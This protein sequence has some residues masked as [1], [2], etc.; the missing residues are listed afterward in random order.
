MAAIPLAERVANGYAAAANQFPFQV[1][2]SGPCGGSLISNAW[3]LCAA[4][5][6]SAPQVNLR[7]G[8]LNRLAGGIAQTSFNRINH[9]NYNPSNLNNDISL[10]SV[11][12]PLTFTP[13]IQSIRLPTAAQVT[14]TFTGAQA[15]V[16]GWGEIFPGSGLQT[17]L[18]WV[19]MR[20]I[21]NAQCAAIYSSYIVVDHVLCALG[22]T[23]PGNQGH[24]T[25]D[26]GGPLTILEGTTRTQIGV[27]SFGA[28]RCDA[29]LPSGYMRTAH[30]IHWI[31][32]LTGIPVR[33]A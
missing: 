31:N 22:Y 28:M 29:G 11:P 2:V 25:G 21:P 32:Q 9:P 4:H 8:S 3:V 18:R 14:S 17:M 33:M 19:H 26:S 5:C 13:A 23:Q 12:S 30:Y 15:T 16:S 6:T 27:V 1:A 10:V 20:V 24:C 7:F